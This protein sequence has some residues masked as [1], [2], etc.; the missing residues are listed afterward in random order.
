[1]RRARMTPLAP[2][3]APGASAGV[4]LAAGRIAVAGERR[5]GYETR[6]VRAA[7]FD[8]DGTLVDNMRFHFDAW[9]A[10]CQ[11]RGFK[12]DP[13]QFGREFAGKKNEEILP[14][15][16][17][18]TLTDEEVHALAEE[19][20]SDYRRIFAQHLQLVPGAGALIARFRSSGAKTA[21]ATAAPPRN[22]DFVLDGLQ[23]WDRFDAVIGA[24]QVLRGKPAPDIFLKAAG[25][26]GI[27]PQDCVVFEDA[28]N[29]IR[30]AKAAGM[31]AVGITTL[32]SVQVLED[33]GADAVLSTF[34]VLPP[35]VEAR[36]FG[37]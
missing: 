23:L 33:A 34:E 32:A 8:L 5:G 6:M 15:L 24:E 26:V 3:N 17:G 2:L 37:G 18:R 36:L 9:D 12:A 27:A 13:E 19:K 25:A 14:V 28:P 21:V 11:K 7:L 31:Y 16:L 30:A 10:F 4:A 20:E 35:A 1:M 29:G 22:R